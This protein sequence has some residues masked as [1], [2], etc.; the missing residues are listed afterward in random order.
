MAKSSI[1]KTDPAGT[2]APKRRSTSASDTSAT[3]PAVKAAAPR[4]RK[5]IETPVTAAAAVASAANEGTNGHEES[6][7]DVPHEQIAVRAYHI[8]LERGYPGDSFHDW[9]TAEREL[10]EQFTRTRG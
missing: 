7:F 5:K 4:S 9:V 10:R 8:H 3:K 6:T 2:T 1:R